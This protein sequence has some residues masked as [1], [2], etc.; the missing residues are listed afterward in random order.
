MLLK[1]AEEECE[2]RADDPVHPADL[3]VTLHTSAGRRKMQR[4][5]LIFSE[6]FP[7]PP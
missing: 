5:L 3:P 2:P 4:A 1:I 7:G 6:D